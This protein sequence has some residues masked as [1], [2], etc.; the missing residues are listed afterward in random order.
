MSEDIQEKTS[1][2]FLSDVEGAEKLFLAGKR[3]REA[4]LESAVRFFLEFLRGFE[5]FDF[6]GP[7]VSVFGSA[8]FDED[9]HYYELARE[10]GAALAEKG[11]A[12]MTGGGP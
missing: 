3:S 9:H 4:D 6:E 1:H 2:S 8:R 12:V 11:Y 10:A 5:S 7:C